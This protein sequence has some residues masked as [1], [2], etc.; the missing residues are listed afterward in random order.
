MATIGRLRG[1][2]VRDA[3]GAFLIICVAKFL[4]A[5][6]VRH[7]FQKKTQ[8]TT[9]ADL[10]LSAARFNSKKKSASCGRGHRLTG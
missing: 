3:S 7:C 2:R 10:D 6:Y 5:V 8:Q 1:I 4:N 9:K